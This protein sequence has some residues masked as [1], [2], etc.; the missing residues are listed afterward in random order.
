MRPAFATLTA[1]L[2][3]LAMLTHVVEAQAQGQTDRKSVV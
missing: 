3:A 2:V 1:A